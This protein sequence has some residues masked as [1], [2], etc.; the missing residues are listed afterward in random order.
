[1]LTHIMSSSDGDSAASIAFERGQQ[2]HSTVCVENL[3]DLSESHRKLV[4]NVDFSKQ[5]FPGINKK[6]QDRVRAIFPMNVTKRCSAEIKQAH[7]QFAGHMTKILRKLSYTFDSIVACV[8]GQCV[9]LC[10]NHAFVC[11]G[12]RKA[13]WKAKFLHPGA[14]L[15]PNNEDFHKLRE[16]IH[17]RLG[18]KALPTA[19]HLDCIEVETPQF[20]MCT[21]P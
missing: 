20:R 14:K 2:T 9:Q 4:K 16:C 15:H 21:P 3:K 5:M 7:K 8:T 12:G 17:L 18:P 6:E 19:L 13:V 11:S 1:M 10:K